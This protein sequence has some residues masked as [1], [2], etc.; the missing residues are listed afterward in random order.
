MG[1]YRYEKFDKDNLPDGVLEEVDRCLHNVANSLFES[2]KG[3]HP[4]IA[5]EVLAQ[6]MVAYMTFY[7]KEE[8]EILRKHANIIGESI[9]HNMERMIV[10]KGLK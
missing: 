6:V 2:M 8:P 10:A 7:L 9:K 4:K 3:V 1:T 5:L